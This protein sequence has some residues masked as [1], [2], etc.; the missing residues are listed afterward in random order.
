MVQGEIRRSGG[1]SR[2]T[3][4]L[5]VQALRKLRA[6]TGCDNDAFGRA[7]PAPPRAPARCSGAWHRTRHATTARALGLLPENWAASSHVKQPGFGLARASGTRGFDLHRCIRNGSIRNSELPARALSEAPAAFRPDLRAPGALPHRGWSSRIGGVGSRRGE[8]TPF[9][10]VR[11]DD[12]LALGPAHT[13]EVV[14]LVDNLL[15]GASR[16]PL[17]HALL[18][19]GIENDDLQTMTFIE[20][21]GVRKNRCG[22]CKTCTN[23]RALSDV[24]CF[25]APPPE[26]G[27][28]A[29]AGRG[30]CCWSH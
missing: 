3:E 14:R 26:G 30:R 19:G 22:R 13:R 8:G 29:R 17:L 2:S 15:P 9:L 27:R 7:P 11:S 12:N 24:I 4:R 1:C 16:H 23:V 20:R 28:S 18:V 6:Q 21:A 5:E 10:D 25:G